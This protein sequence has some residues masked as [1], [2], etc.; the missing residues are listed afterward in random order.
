MGEARKQEKWEDRAWRARLH[1]G[2][3][4]GHSSIR[5]FEQSAIRAVGQ[6]AIRAVGSRVAG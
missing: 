4:I 3:A 6:S 5:P 2:R 1:S